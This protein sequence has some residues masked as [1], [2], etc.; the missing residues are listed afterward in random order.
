MSSR[1]NADRRF[2]L[3]RKLRDQR[4]S[5]L[6]IRLRNDL[7]E[8]LSMTFL[9]TVLSISGLPVR[10]ANPH[11]LSHQLWH[12]IILKLL[13]SSSNSALGSMFSISRQRMPTA[14][15]STEALSGSFS[16]TSGARY[17]LSLTSQY[18][19]GLGLPTLA[20][21]KPASV[22]LSVLLKRIC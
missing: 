5:W 13:A 10:R 2:W 19:P 3:G 14:Q 16:K 21:L 1:I 8:T 6:F 7:A 17:L 9:T 11:I 22:K 12:W 20:R 15:T 18:S 4:A